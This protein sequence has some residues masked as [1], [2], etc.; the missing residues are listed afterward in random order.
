MSRTLSLLALFI[1]DGVTPSLWPRESIAVVCGTVRRVGRR[2]KRA[3]LP[4]AAVR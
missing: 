1:L 4:R 3:F 2:S